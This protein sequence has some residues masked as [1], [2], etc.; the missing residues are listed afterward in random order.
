MST[1]GPYLLLDSISLRSLL[2]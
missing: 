2:H 1:K